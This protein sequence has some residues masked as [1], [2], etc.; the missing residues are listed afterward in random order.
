MQKA[1]LKSA[2]GG[3]DSL[4]LMAFSI[5]QRYLKKSCGF[6]VACYTLQLLSYLNDKICCVGS[7]RSHRFYGDGVE[8]IYITHR[9]ELDAFFLFSA[10]SL[11]AP[12]PDAAEG[13]T[14]LTQIKSQTAHR[15]C[16]HGIIVA[17]SGRFLSSRDKPAGSM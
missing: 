16:D 10:H 1:S 5:A 15:P 12:A 13:A 2:A 3:G 17:P 8:M 11:G 7:P 4:I 9:E 14:L 6:G